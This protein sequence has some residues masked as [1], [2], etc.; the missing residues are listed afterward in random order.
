MA[1]LAKAFGVAP[2]KPAKGKPKLVA[3]S[4]APAAKAAPMKMTKVKK[5][6]KAKG[7]SYAKK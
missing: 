2:A 3:P 1:G 6:P 4:K 7:D 5:V